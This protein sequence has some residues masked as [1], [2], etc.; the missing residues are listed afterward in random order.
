MLL[1]TFAVGEKAGAFKS[2]IDAVC[3]VRQIGGIA[4]GSDVYT[5]AVDDQVIAVDFDCAI[6]WAV[7]R[8]ALE[9]A[10]IGLGICQ[11]VDRL[12]K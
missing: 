10:G 3:L 9:Q 1:P 12:I 2:D 8:I 4:L 6:E 11:I 5:L 7:D